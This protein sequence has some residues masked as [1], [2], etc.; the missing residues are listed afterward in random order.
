VQLRR[1]ALQVPRAEAVQGA[2]AARATRAQAEAGRMSPARVLA[3]LGAMMITLAFAGP[4]ASARIEH[5]GGIAFQRTLGSRLPLT[6][7]M[8]GDDVA[9]LQQALTVAGF[10]VTADG[11]FGAATEQALEAWEA[12]SARPVDGIV[13]ADDAA[14]LLGVLATATP[15][16][17]AP[18][19][20]PLPTPEPT[21]APT[22]ATATINSAG[23]A[24]AAPGS[25]VRV[26][27]IVAAAN[28]IATL[29][30]RFG[31]G[32]GRFT[33]TAYDCS[34]SVSY[35]LHGA[36]LLDTTLDST[37]LE[38]FGAAGPGRWV[39]IYA[40]AGHTYMVIEGLRFDTSGAV[41]AGTR[42]QADPRP[43]TGYVIRHPAGL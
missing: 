7:G 13:D 10:P 37:G 38:H 8:S 16:T 36:K 30:Y 29:P 15:I 32:H 39:T 43:S 33:D 21:P 34:G 31:G 35:A 11:Q 28:H 26:E 17:P 41:Q 12:A 24:V 2:H 4:G 14:A 19:P 22:A 20:A 3:V 1:P 27:R 18:D 9:S 40:N 5:G 25:P 23:H 6:P 42:W